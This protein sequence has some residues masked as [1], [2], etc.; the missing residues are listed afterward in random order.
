MSILLRLGL[1]ACLLATACHRG[2]GDGDGDGASGSAGEPEN[3]AAEPAVAPAD[4]AVFPLARLAVDPF[5]QILAN[6]PTTLARGKTFDPNL[7]PIYLD[8][9]DPFGPKMTGT[10][11]FD[12]VDIDY[13]P[14]GWERYSVMRPVDNME[15]AGEELRYV[16]DLFRKVA[17]PNG[18]LGTSDLSVPSGGQRKFKLAPIE[19]AVPAPEF[20][21]VSADHIDFFQRY[22]GDGIRRSE[23][24]GRLEVKAVEG[25]PDVVDYK[26]FHST[27]AP[28]DP[29]FRNYTT[30]SWRSG[31]TQ[32]E[33]LQGYKRIGSVAYTHAKAELNWIK[34]SASPTAFLAVG[35][36]RW[37]SNAEEAEFTSPDLLINIINAEMDMFAMSG[38]PG[39]SEVALSFAP[40]LPSQAGAL[41]FKANNET[42]VGFDFGEQEKS[43]V[44]K[45]LRNAAG[46][47]N[48]ATLG[49]AIRAGYDDPGSVPAVATALPDDL[50]ASNADVKDAELVGALEAICFAAVRPAVDLGI[51][52]DEKSDGN[53]Y[54]LC[55]R[56]YH[57][58]IV[59]NPMQLGL[60]ENMPSIVHWQDSIADTGKTKPLSDVYSVLMN[61][62]KAVEFDF[63]PLKSAVDYDV[64]EMTYD[65]LTADA[66]AS[67]GTG[68]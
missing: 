38:K 17:G 14:F 50:C 20:A 6:L 48:C 41:G 10:V 42:F 68:Q 9:S 33:V 1:F 64:T 30:I 65:E 54:D 60:D 51:L 63:S 29:N 24:T 23:R 21:V 16:S 46:D 31:D 37:F 53:A 7:E 27:V 57:Y 45:L 44:V 40:L 58:G 4:Q 25:K 49:S 56:V 66:E 62:L 61:S 18:W 39:S 67:P 22:F 55:E 5:A 11:A 8:E 12:G 34:L 35:G 3:P 13:D 2:G 43:L 28:E 36:W 19:S 52:L 47:V 59:K 26:F 32:V 15:R